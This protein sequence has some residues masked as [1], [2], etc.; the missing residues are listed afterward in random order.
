MTYC[1]DILNLKTIVAKALIDGYTN[2]NRSSSNTRPSQQKFHKLCMTR[3]VPTHI[4]EFQQKQMKSIYCKSESS[5]LK[6]FVSCQACGLNLGLTKGINC[7]YFSIT[8][9]LLTTCLLEHRLFLCRLFRFLLCLLCIHICLLVLNLT[10]NAEIQL[11]SFLKSIYN[12]KVLFIELH[13]F[14]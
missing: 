8:I 13:L 3:E 14:Q 10:K 1:D 9:S 4:P 7:L 6:C 11:Q 2:R 12:S 5:D